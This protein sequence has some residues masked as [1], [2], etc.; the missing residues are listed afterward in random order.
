MAS[1]ARID[2]LKKKF[3]ENPRRYFA[4][5]ANEFRKAGDLEQAIMICEEFL[6]QQPGHMSGHIV[7][8]QALY[9]GGR[10]DDARVVFE[11]ALSLDPE[12]LIALRHLGD[13]ARVQGDAGAA[14]TWYDRVL[15]ADPRN[16]EIQALITSLDPAAAAAAEAEAVRK[17]AEENDE[18]W[19]RA[20]TLAQMPAGGG[21]GSE[22]AATTPPAS[23]TPAQDLSSMDTIPFGIPAIPPPIPFAQPLP[24]RASTAAPA[25]PSAPVW[26]SEAEARDAARDAVSLDGLEPTD[27]G[28]G[29]GS[30]ASHRAEGLE[31]SEFEAPSSGVP[32]PLDLADSIESGEFVAPSSGVAPLAGL[33][34]H[35]IGGGSAQHQHTADDLGAIDLDEGLMLSPHGDT[36]AESRTAPAGADDAL[37][38]ESEDAMTLPPHGDALEP[39]S[40]ERV[41]S[42]DV[43][44]AELAEF[45]IPSAEAPPVPNPKMEPPAA[46][47]AMP[48]LDMMTAAA[49]P[50][51]LPAAVLAGQVAIAEANESASAP[52]MEE[53]G[54]VAPTQAPFV[55]ETMAELYIT[56][57]FRDQ[58]LEVYRQL[59]EANPRD[60]RLRAKVAEL[61]SAPAASAAVTGPTVRE[62]LARLA[63]RQPGARAQ[64][65]HLPAADDFALEEPATDDFAAQEPAAL[66]HAAPPAHEPQPEPAPAPVAAAPAPRISGQVAPAL[67]RAAATQRPS[68]GTID[69]LFGNRTVPHTE[70]SAAAALSQAFGGSS[71]A[72]AISGR[73]ARAA[74]SELSLDSV[75]RDGPSSRAARTSQSFSFDQFFSEG[76]S[77]DKGGGGVATPERG[78][79]GAPAEKSADDIE[80]FNSWLQGLKQR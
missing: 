16:D 15:E 32:A 21:E 7:Y 54:G 28:H 62:F 9:E 78:A 2:E 1:S 5:L 13:I 14:R 47:E 74:E 33:E 46:M 34:D 36:L 48:A 6:P 59:S 3:D 69:A 4:P 52:A 77:G 29:H 41:A 24:P 64:A 75:F 26:G 65:A 72:P 51:E 42:G 11:T 61:S 35:S 57:G 45:D 55:T 50:V 38:I 27:A 20:S 63:S 23:P 71:D 8:G 53:G 43:A 17:A 25:A 40:A 56:Q 22:P 60:Q 12:N 66:S 79:Q 67:E 39:V 30:V 10:L 18:P 49:E 31:P 68:G 37:E 44:M 80:Q 19:A 58:A 76:A 70:D 73:P